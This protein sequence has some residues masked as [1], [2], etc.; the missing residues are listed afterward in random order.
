MDTLPPRISEEISFSAFEIDKPLGE[1]LVESG[2]S[3]FKGDF[4]TVRVLR[5]L[6]EA[7]GGS[8]DVAYDAYLRMGPITLGRS[9]YETWCESRRSDIENLKFRGCTGFCVNGV[10]L[11]R[12]HPLFELD[13][14]AIQR[15][16]PVADGHRPLLAD[17]A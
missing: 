13:R 15:C 17:V 3:F 11:T 2:E 16:F 10:S 14:K 8:Y 4:E 12:L 6:A 9:E 1:W 5:S 7:A